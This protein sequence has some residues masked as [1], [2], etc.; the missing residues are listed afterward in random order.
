MTAIIAHQTLTILS[1]FAVAILLVI[2]LLIARFY[3]SVSGERTHFWLFGAPI[4][5]WGMAS[6]RYAFLGEVGGD[7]LGDVL[8][9]V[10]GVLLAGLCIY[11]YNLMTAGR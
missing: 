1:W 11:L 5:F 4:I 2:L 9:L 10:G 6:A 8:W 7:P 3:E